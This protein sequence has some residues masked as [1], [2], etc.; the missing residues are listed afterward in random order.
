MPW[1]YFLVERNTFLMKVYKITD[2]R[3]ICQNKCQGK[4]SS[5]RFKKI[6]HQ[7][8]TFFTE[9]AVNNNSFWMKRSGCNTDLFQR[10]TRFNIF[11]VSIF[12]IRSSI[13][14]FQNFTPV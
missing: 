2:Q 6:L 8:S 5:S 3:L 1:F 4:I 13:S 7:V 9:Y 11:S 10:W 14:Y 12:Y